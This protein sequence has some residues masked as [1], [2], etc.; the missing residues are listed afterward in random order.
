M[1]LDCDD[2]LA[3]GA[4]SGIL[5]GSFTLDPALHPAGAARSTSGARC[6][7]QIKCPA[8]RGLHRQSSLARSGWRSPQ[9]TGSG[10]NKRRDAG[11]AGD[12]GKL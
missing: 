4:G 8:I 12:R 11:I 1:L 10:R 3:R 2:P 5:D 7:E 9:T 6:R